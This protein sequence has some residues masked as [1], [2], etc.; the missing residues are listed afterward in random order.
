LKL[1]SQA[2]LNRRN[3]LKIKFIYKFFYQ[4]VHLHYIII[5]WINLNTL[6]VCVCIYI[7]IYINLSTFLLV[8][9]LLFYLMKLSYFLNYF[10]FFFTNIFFSFTHHYKIINGVVIFMSAWKI[11]IFFLILF[12]LIQNM[13]LFL[14][15]FRFGQ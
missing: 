4:T 8:F 6:F 12:K 10:S 7:Y 14:I 5:L 9:Y 2:A 3:L 11:I 1:S 13:K 15:F